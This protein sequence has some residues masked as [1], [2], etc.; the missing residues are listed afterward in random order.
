MMPLNDTR[1][2]NLKPHPEKA[3]R[4]V[5]DGSGLYIRVRAG[6]GKK[7]QIV[8]TWQF[9]C[10]V[11]SKLTV[12]TLGTYPALPLLEA[13]QQALEL[14]TKGKSYSPT[15]EVAAEQWLSERIDHTHR[16]AEL[17]R[18]YVER[19]VLPVL[20]KRRVR[21]IE[22]SEIAAVVRAYRDQT[23]K[24]ALARKGGLTAARALLGVFKGLFG[25]AVASGWIKHS[26]AA[27]LTAAVVGPPS[28]ARTRVLSDDEIEFVMTTDVRQGPVLRFLLLTGLRIGEA[29]NGHRE[30]QYWVVPPEF[31]KNRRE[32]RVWLSHLALAQLEL[33][34]WEA[35]RDD[36]QH[37]LAATSKGW[38]AH[39]LRR[40]F[41]TR[42]NGMGVAPHIVEKM[43]NHTLGG[44]MGIYN[45][46]DYVAERKEALEAWSAWLRGMTDKRSADVVPLRS[47][48]RRTA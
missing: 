44:V 3:E 47:A 48:G 6:A 32:H 43:I 36:V 11:G 40:T 35:T 17:I 2:R 37:W 16:R 24:K 22:P 12:T 20:G 30:G 1:L 18:G 39:D 21:D 25:Y 5:A 9:R 7:P 31:S 13:R 38:S 26:P 8:R 10:K 28:A 27:Q 45:R 29:Y 34:P 23:A 42:N 46:A 19:G 14:A 15:V 4:L 41:S 33:H